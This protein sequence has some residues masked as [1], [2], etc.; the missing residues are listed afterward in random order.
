MRR[1]DGTRPRRLTV[2]FALISLVAY[3]AHELRDPLLSVESNGNRLVVVA[4]KT[5]ERGVC[6]IK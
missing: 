3:P 1:G 6:A 4:E 2:D 5:S